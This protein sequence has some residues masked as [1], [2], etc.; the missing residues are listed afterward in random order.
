MTE[1]KEASAQE[2]KIVP[3]DPEVENTDADPEARTEAEDPE[4]EIEAGDL[5]AETGIIDPEAEMEGKS[6]KQV[7]EE[8]KMIDENPRVERNLKKN[9]LKI[10]KWAMSTKGK[11]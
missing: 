6:T 8:E 10:L 1:R 9:F 3:E 2:A 7:I 5:E 4:A 11:S